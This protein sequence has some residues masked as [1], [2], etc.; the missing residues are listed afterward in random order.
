[1]KS[2]RT[3]TCTVRSQDVSA[4]GP[5][6]AFVASLTRGFAVTCM[7]HSPSR[8]ERDTGSATCTCCRSAAA[9][10]DTILA[11]QCFASGSRS[12]SAQAAP[13][14]TLNCP[15]RLE[16]G[17][18][19][20]GTRSCSLR[21][22]CPLSSQETASKGDGARRLTQ[23]GGTKNRACQ[24]HKPSHETEYAGTQRASTSKCPTS[25]CPIACT[26]T[27]MHQPERTLALS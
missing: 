11:L 23:A 10:C 26:A 12:L 1:M 4:H 6:H 14:S 16:R 15:R 25:N 27:V 8:H 13:T 7:S 18:A 24:G 20:C 2:G 21:T 9:A 5:Q 17:T 22:S 19:A 3:S